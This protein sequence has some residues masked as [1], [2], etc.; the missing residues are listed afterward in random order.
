MNQDVQYRQSEDTSMVLLD[1][2][3]WDWRNPLNVL[4]LATA[5]I[6]LASVAVILNGIFAV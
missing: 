2:I 3:N 4:P 6:I 5:A 1:H